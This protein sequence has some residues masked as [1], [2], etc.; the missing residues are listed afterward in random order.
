MKRRVGAASRVAARVTIR[1]KSNFR[2]EDVYLDHLI[3]VSDLI[4]VFDGGRF[5]LLDLHA[6][7][8]IPMT[9]IFIRDLEWQVG[10]VSGP[11][12]P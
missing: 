3:N 8:S 6:R 12:L 11:G 9:Y 4:G 2:P 5:T 7:V 10:A 1:S